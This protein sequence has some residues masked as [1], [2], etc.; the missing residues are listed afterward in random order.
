MM[1]H[2]ETVCKAVKFEKTGGLKEK[3]ANMMEGRNNK[4]SQ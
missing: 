1:L 4:T 2:T 3:D